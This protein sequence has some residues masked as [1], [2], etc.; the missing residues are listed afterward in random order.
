MKLYNQEKNVHVPLQN[1]AAPLSM[2][3]CALAMQPWAASPPHIIWKISLLKHNSLWWHSLQDLLCL[4]KARAHVRNWWLSQILLMWFSFIGSSFFK[5]GF[6]KQHVGWMMAARV[7][8]PLYPSTQRSLW[9]T[10]AGMRHRELLVGFLVRIPHPH[11]GYPQ[12]AAR[13]VPGRLSP[14][15]PGSSGWRSS[16]H[17]SRCIQLCLTAMAIPESHHPELRLSS[18]SWH[19]SPCTAQ[20]FLSELPLLMWQFRLQTPSASPKALVSLPACFHSLIPEIPSQSTEGPVLEKCRR[21]LTFSVFWYVQR[22]GHKEHIS[23][24]HYRDLN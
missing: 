13:S 6:L 10:R 2:L 9:S 7:Q 15:P 19:C 21:I 22:P 24:M 17:G 23:A 3:P 11:S 1:D 20:L 16:G 12:N 4:G 8:I 5:L 14:D 18:T